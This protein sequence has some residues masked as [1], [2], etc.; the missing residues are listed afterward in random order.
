[1][2][3]VTRVLSS[4]VIRI[5][6]YEV[7]G[8]SLSSKKVQKV[9]VVDLGSGGIGVTGFIIYFLNIYENLSM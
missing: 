7:I 1:M 2:N 8:A 3:P 9:R 4:K 6:K 5:C